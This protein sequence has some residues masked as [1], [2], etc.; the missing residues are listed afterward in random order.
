MAYGG[1]SSKGKPVRGGC[2][3]WYTKVGH[4][5]CCPGSAGCICTNPSRCGKA[6]GGAGGGHGGS[7]GGGHVQ[8]HQHQHGHQHHH[9]H[10]HGHG[11]YGHHKHV[12]KHGSHKHHV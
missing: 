3:G 6:G 10:K 7:V 8:G 1:S 11:G 9:G 12:V 4:H 2:A 5:H